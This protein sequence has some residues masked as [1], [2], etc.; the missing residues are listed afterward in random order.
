MYST[1]LSGLERSGGRGI[2]V[3]SNDQVFVTGRAGLGFVG[4][5]TTPIQSIFG[6]RSDAF[7]TKINSLGT[8]VVYSTHLGGDGSEAGASIAVDNWGNVYVTGE[9]STKGSSFPGT[10]YSPIQN[11]FAG[12]LSDAFL[13]KINASGTAIVYS[14][15]LGGNNGDTGDDGGMG[16]A[17]DAAGQAYVTGWT[18]GPGSGFPG[19]SQSVIQNVNTA[20]KNAFVTKI[21][22]TGTGLLYSTYLGNS[23]TWG[24]AIAIDP[25][26]N[27]YV[28]GQT[29]GAGF[30]GTAGNSIQETFGG[31]SDAFLVKINATGTALLYSTYL[32]ATGLNMAMEL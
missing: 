30:P 27:A 21:N 6:G 16:V 10:A 9:T 18:S 4:T 29:T 12:G 25:A 7:V 20:R 26:G 2:A 32:G 24:Y 14:T 31:E 28:T 1:Y 15:Y 8:A 3:D 13:T 23:A 19:T 5:A 17:V 11:T 22:A